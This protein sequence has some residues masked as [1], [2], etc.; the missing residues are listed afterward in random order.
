[1]ITILVSIDWNKSSIIKSL[2][3]IVR[4]FILVDK[5]NLHVLIFASIGNCK[6][7]VV[8]CNRSAKELIKDGTKDVS[9]KG[10]QLRT[11][12]IT[13]LKGTSKKIVLN[14]LNS[15]SA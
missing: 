3:R 8:D 11:N 4:Q 5:L 15:V 14:V 2:V 1:M 6:K 10:S 9:S 7:M 12:A 13:S